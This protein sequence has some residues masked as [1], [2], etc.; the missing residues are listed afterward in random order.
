MKDNPRFSAIY[1]TIVRILIFYVG[2][3]LLGIVLMSQQQTTII[4]IPLYLDYT[5]AAAGVLLLIFRFILP[6]FGIPYPL[7]FDKTEDDH[8]EEE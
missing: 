2:G 1:E 7:S 4:E 5:V 8:T 6:I 3:G